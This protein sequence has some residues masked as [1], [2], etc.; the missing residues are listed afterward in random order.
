MKRVSTTEGF[1]IVE[2][3]IVIVVIAILA[4][5]TIV[6]YN[7][8]QN[9]TYDSSVRADIASIAKKMELQKNDTAG[10]SYP[11][12]NT[13][14]TFVVRV[15]KAA[16]AT[17][18]L[19]FNLIFCM[20]TASNAKQFLLLATSKSGKR[21]TIENG[22]GIQE[23]NGGVSWSGS[24]GDTICSAMRSGWIGALAGY[25]ASDTTTGPWRSWAGGN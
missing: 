7:G 17:N 2:L 16:Y 10:E 18:G 22:G 9:G 14:V 21:Y 11:Y 15:N 6:A 23:Y 20:P 3:L 1:T 19:T 5:I 13:S 25:N 8:I 12:G 4:A 24:T